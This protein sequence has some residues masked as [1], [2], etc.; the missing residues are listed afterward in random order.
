MPTTTPVEQTLL[1]ALNDSNPNN[2]AAALSQ[3]N[4]GN[5]LTP[6]T[7]TVT[8]FTGGITFTLDD[9]SPLAILMVSV[10]AAG[11]G[12]AGNYVEHA[13]AVAPTSDNLVGTF[14]INAARTQITLPAG[15]A[16]TAATVRYIRNVSTALTTAF[17]VAPH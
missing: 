13:V 11:A 15:T 2:L 14:T 9:A 1:S 5:M 4:I 17:G 10:T 6:V 16:A 7:Q 3:L 12:R 8:T